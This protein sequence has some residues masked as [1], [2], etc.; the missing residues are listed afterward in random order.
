MRKARNPIASQALAF[1]LLNFFGALTFRGLRFLRLMPDP[2]PFAK[3]KIQKILILRPDMVGDVVLVTPLIKNTRENFPQAHIAVVVSGIT[4]DIV[5]GNPYLNEVI[6]VSGVGMSNL[7]KDMPLIKAIRKRQFDLALVAF[8]AFSCNLFAF[9]TGVAH[10]VGYGDRGSRYLL[11]KPL[12]LAGFE[13]RK[14]HMIDL[15]LDTLRALGCT[16]SSRKEYVSVYPDSENNAAR[17]FLDNG[18]KAGDKAVIMH[19]GA[20]KTYQ[21]W[22]VPKFAAL[23]DRLIDELKVKVILLKGPVDGDLV[24]KTIAGMRNKAIA[25][26]GFQLKDTIS[27]IKRCDLFIGH[28]TGTTHIADALGVNTIML[29]AF[30]GSCD[31]P[32]VWGTSGPNSVMVTN[33]TSCGGCIPSDCKDSY[34]IRGITVEDVFTAAKKQ[35]EKDV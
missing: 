14:A 3:E 33:D 10:R 18:I 20:R 12:V 9:L 6:A 19:P 4:K 5:S 31:S 8:P 23:A 1:I 13:K 24:E 28:S 2:A 11:T 27:L 30:F 21:L 22:P 15:N 26:S 29:I 34:C 25:A 16:V 7:I 17:F 35:L 32:A